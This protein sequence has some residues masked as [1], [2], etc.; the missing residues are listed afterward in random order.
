MKTAKLDHCSRDLRFIVTQDCNYDCTFCHK[1]RMEWNEKQ[2]LNAQDYKFIYKTWKQ[3][4]PL[5]WV[6]L[7]GW[8]PLTRPDIKNIL[9]ELKEENAKITM[10]SNWAILWKREW[11]AD[12]L[13]RLS[14]SLHTTNQELYE[15]ITNTKTKV[16]KVMEHIRLLKKK[17]PN[18][19]LRINAAL[20]ENTTAKTEEINKMLDFVKDQELTIK[21]LELS[22]P[23]SKWF[24]K[25]ERIIPLLEKKWF[26]ESKDEERKEKIFRKWKATV[27]IRRNMCKLVQEEKLNQEYCK[28]NGDINISPDWRISPCLADQ[29]KFWI[30][31]I[32]KERDEN[33]L[34]EIFK[35]ATAKE[36]NYKCSL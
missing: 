4:I 30:Y 31:E 33:K 35:Q 28:N 6:T 23:Y 24:F 20:V 5:H 27:T 29:K 36:T 3:N 18:L 22:P 32:V 9:Q 15:S 25:R 12:F 13:D 8:E 14:V 26:E 10:I 19:D 11:I 16:E 7:T 1:E 21:Y 34:G 2:L 17:Y